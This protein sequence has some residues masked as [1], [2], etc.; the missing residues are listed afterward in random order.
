MKLHF[1][2]IKINITDEEKV[3]KEHKDNIS[4]YSENKLYF[5]TNVFW[6]D[7]LEHN[8]AVFKANAVVPF[9]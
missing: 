9:M 5:I 7:E 6:S 2:N 8:K 3:A 1:Y 4:C